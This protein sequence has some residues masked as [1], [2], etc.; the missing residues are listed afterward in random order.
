MEI[1]KKVVVRDIKIARERIPVQLGLRQK[2]KVRK[3]GS[4]VVFHRREIRSK[5][6]HVSKGNRKPPSTPSPTTTQIRHLT[7][8]K[9]TRTHALRHARTDTLTQAL[10]QALTRTR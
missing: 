10:T 5:A 7:K 6:T 2:Q 9:K 1:V 8:K 3:R 4:E